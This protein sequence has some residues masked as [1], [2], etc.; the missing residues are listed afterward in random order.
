MTKSF[1]KHEQLYS[2]AEKAADPE[3]LKSDLENWLSNVT[4]ENDEVLKKLESIWMAFLKRK[5]N[6]SSPKTTPKVKSA[7]QTSKTSTSRISK[8]SSQRQW[9]LL[10]AKNRREEIE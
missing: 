5:R 7:S 8:T 9:E 6:Q 10:L 4:V 3:A 2:F 1:G